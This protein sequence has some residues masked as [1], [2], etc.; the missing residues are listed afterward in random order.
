MLF[1]SGLA[2]YF[3]DV[4]D[5]KL[6]EQELQ[7]ALTKLEESERRKDEFLALL[8]HELRNPLAPI[9]NGLSLL[10]LRGTAEPVS[11]RA[12]GIME[13]QLSH[14]VRLVDDLLDV[15]RLT[16]GKLRLRVQRVSL[17]DILGHALEAA[18]AALE[19]RGHTLTT[20]VRAHD[21]MLEGDADRL[22]QVFTN[23]V[24]NSIKYTDKIGRAH[25]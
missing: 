18:H 17:L 19:S 12:L 11:Q 16:H 8:S 1:R 15:G 25:V 21:L 23:L 22:I 4:S 10:K 6:A 13:R 14:L 3:R 5:R 2:V 9:A 24:Q 20:D 7:A